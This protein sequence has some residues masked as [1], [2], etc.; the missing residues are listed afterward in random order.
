[1]TEKIMFFTAGPVATPQ[2]IADIAALRSDAN[3]KPA[4]EV[5]V[6]NGAVPNT[7]GHGVEATDFVAGT[8][9]SAYSAKPVFGEE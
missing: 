3:V 2:E 9:P 4:Y 8:V 6:R 5:V 7:Y 1:M